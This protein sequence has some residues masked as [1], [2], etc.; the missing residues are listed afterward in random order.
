MPDD[1][2]T[3]AAATAENNAAGSPHTD[4]NCRNCGAALAGPYCH[5]CGQKS[6]HLHRPIW[7][8]FEDFLHTVIHFDGRMAQTLKALFLQPGQMSRDWVD[9]KQMRYVPPIRL[10]I[11]TSLLLVILLA[12]SDVALVQL[13]GSLDLGAAS[14]ATQQAIEADRDVDLKAGIRADFFSLVRPHQKTAPLIAPE[15]QQRVDN[16]DARKTM[17][18]LSEHINAFGQDPA[19]LNKAITGSISPFVLIAAPIM[20]VLLKLFYV[21]RKHFLAEHLVFALHTHTFFFASL[22]LAVLLT[23][24]SRGALGGEAML[25]AV[26]LAFLVYALLAMKKMYSQ[27]W[28]KTITKASIIAVLYTLVL[29]FVG[30]ALFVRWL[31]NVIDTAA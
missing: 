19:R 3:L 18:S 26:W 6:V 31:K 1:I 23:W 12:I 8:L 5:V 27:G 22:F 13:R 24:V 10:F 28:S 16:K 30:T 14:A 9:G 7:E 11:F 20:A 2:T 15:V 21:R 4:N 17:R 25:A 29:S